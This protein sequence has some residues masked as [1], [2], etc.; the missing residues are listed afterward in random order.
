MPI[1]AISASTPP[2]RRGRFRTFPKSTSVSGVPGVSTNQPL[3]SPPRRRESSA[4]PAAGATPGRKR[5]ATMYGLG[6]SKSL[7]V[8]RRSAAWVR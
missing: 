3:R 6:G 5:T 1:A 2:S 8:K 7:G 4:R